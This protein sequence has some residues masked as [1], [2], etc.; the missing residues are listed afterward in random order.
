MKKYLDLAEKILRKVGKPL[1]AERITEQADKLGLL[2][3]NVCGDRAHTPQHTMRARLSEDIRYNKESPFQRTNRGVFALREWSMKDYLAKRI[4]R[5]PAPISKERVLVVPAEALKRL[6]Y[7]HGISR[8]TR[9]WSR[10]LLE[11][12]NT[13]FVPSEEAESTEDYKQIIPY[14]LVQKNG[15]LLRFQRGSYSNAPKMLK[16]KYSIGFG[17][18]IRQEDRNLLSWDDNG[19]SQGLER[20]LREELKF[21]PPILRDFN[22]PL[23]GILNDDSSN[24]GRKHIALVHLL[25]LDG[26]SG[27]ISRGE[28]SIN[29]TTLVNV[30]TFPGE[31]E[32]YEYW[33]KLCIREFFGKALTFRARVKE[34]K[35]PKISSRDKL[36]LV[37]GNTGSGKTEVARAICERFGFHMISSSQVL[38]RILDL[39]GV[40][41]TVRSSFQEAASRFIQEVNGPIKLADQI[42]HDI[43]TANQPC[44]VDG[45]RN[46]ATYDALANRIGQRIPIVYVE[47]TPKDALQFFRL[48]EDHSMEAKEFMRILDHP[49]E[50]EVPEFSRLA[51]LIVYNYGS[52]RSLRTEVLRYLA[53]RLRRD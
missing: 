45:I 33:S 9:L 21:D 13:M 37:V 10:V 20:E 29:Q 48:R 30:G 36:I 46:L 43:A 35:R 14:V 16:G 24:V 50:A 34:F 23:V 32:L 19:Y 40:R 53:T 28:Q 38:R 2:Y 51:S 26:F 1:S 49:T 15:A 17:G 47:T 52:L 7:F 27:K 11:P 31:Y 8:A 18:H 22:P 5:P 4:Q 44:V 41:P 6:P 3:P 25:S 12:R 39:R 42:A